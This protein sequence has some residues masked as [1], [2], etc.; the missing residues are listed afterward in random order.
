MKCDDYTNMEITRKEGGG[1]GGGG[2]GHEKG[3]ENSKNGII[4][5]H[6]CDVVFIIS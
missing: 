4:G 6:S 3:K 1:G 5:S 2:Q